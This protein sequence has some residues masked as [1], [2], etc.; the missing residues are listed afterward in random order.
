MEFWNNKRVVVTGGK[1]FLGSYVVEALKVRNCKEVISLGS[2]DC[3]LT[4]INEVKRLYSRFNPEI[5]IHLA[6]AVGGIGA[7][8]AYPGSYF[9]K[10][11]IMG[12]QL[13]EQA[14]LNNV[15]K[16]VNVGTICCYPKIT[17][18][19][20]K[21][22]SLWDGYPDEITGY[23]GMAKK[24]LL[25]QSEG[26][27][28]EYDF[29]SIFLMPTNL[30]G[31]RDNFK[32]EHAHVMPALINKFYDAK[33]NNLPNVVCWGTGKATREFLHVKECA[34][35]ILLAAEKYN[36]SEPINLGTGTET[37]IKYLSE[38]IKE[39]MGY[40]GDII[41]DTTR[42]DGQPRRCLDVTRAKEK[43]GFVSKIAIEDGLKET[44]DWY[45]KYRYETED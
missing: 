31:P 41:W 14:R 32:G 1:G 22:E 24:M 35:G 45:N 34:Q 18:V 9:Y 6:A 3:D 5:V 7:N 16:F 33:K 26:Y 40:D 39:Y 28:K 2:K 10:N 37:T 43:F 11:I 42:P 21:E 27:R 23:Y 36:S 20:F 29:N 25:I 30:Y 17:A 8:Q 44:I 38:L 19:P 12:T 15:E 4:D 13:M